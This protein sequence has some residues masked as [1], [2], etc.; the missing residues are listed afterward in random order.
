MTSVDDDVI[1]LDRFRERR[2]LKQGDDR[3]HIYVWSRMLVEGRR[4]IAAGGMTLDNEI[5]VRGLVSL[6]A[7]AIKG[8]E[9]C[10]VLLA[11]YYAR[12]E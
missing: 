1:S 3:E 9:R 12:T 4:L 7:G 5:L 10:A 6:L 2:Q 8:D 11:K